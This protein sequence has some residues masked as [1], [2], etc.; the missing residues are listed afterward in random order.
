MTRAAT[1][2]ANGEIPAM[3]R[4][5][6]PN[7]GRQNT[8]AR[9]ENKNWVIVTITIT[10]AAATTQLSV[11]TMKLGDSGNIKN[12]TSNSMEVLTM[13]MKTMAIRQ[14]QWQWRSI[15]PYNRLSLSFTKTGEIFTFTSLFYA[16]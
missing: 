14:L 10:K 12:R 9:D 11:M 3:E 7:S 16:T 15:D 5:T 8:S 2:M 1:I 4:K 6:V 13:A